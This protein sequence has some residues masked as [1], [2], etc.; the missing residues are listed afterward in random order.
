MG[1]KIQEASGKKECKST[2]KKQIKVFKKIIN[3]FIRYHP[4]H[5]VFKLISDLI[6]S[7]K[8]N[9]RTTREIRKIFIDHS[10]DWQKRSCLEKRKI[11]KLMRAALVEIKE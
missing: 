2:A 8:P 5:E 6:V 1:M 11:N 10:L 7:E 4:P 9:V 3:K